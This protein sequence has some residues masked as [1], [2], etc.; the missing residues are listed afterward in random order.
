MAK[1][2]YLYHP[3]SKIELL[4]RTDLDKIRAEAIKEFSERVNE[5][6]EKARQKYQRLCKEQGEKEDE[7]MN[8]IFRGFMKIVDDFA[9]EMGVE[10]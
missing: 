1:D 8:I 5:K 3:D 2:R 4:P 9:K 6:T 10:L 7:A